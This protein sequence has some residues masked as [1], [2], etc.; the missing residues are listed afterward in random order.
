[1]V[2]MYGSAD[3]VNWVA[4]G[5]EKEVSMAPNVYEDMAVSNRTRNHWRQRTF[6][7]VSVS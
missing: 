3:G 4:L 2:R 1:M 7:S 5:Y 6:D